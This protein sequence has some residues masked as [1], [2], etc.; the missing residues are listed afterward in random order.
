VSFVGGCDGSAYIA[1]VGVFCLALAD[2][3]AV[4]DCERAR[5]ASH[6]EPDVVSRRVPLH[7]C[8]PHVAAE[9]GSETSRK[10]DYALCDPIRKAN[11]LWRRHVVEKDRHRRECKRRAAVSH[12]RAEYQGNHDDEAATALRGGE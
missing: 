1:D 3:E 5:R 8:G 9:E 12:S 4:D 11:D 2:E 10:R 6:D 7:C